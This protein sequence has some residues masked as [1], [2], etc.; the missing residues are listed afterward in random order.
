MIPQWNFFYIDNIKAF[1]E[2]EVHLQSFLYSTLEG[3]CGQLHIPATLLPPRSEHLHPSWLG[4][5]ARTVLD[6]VVEK[7]LSYPF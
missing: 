1:D 7:K 6:V 3:M 5:D 4:V 2:V